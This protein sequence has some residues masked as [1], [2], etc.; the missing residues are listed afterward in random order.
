MAG[1]RP[2]PHHA[3]PSRH[4]V[5]H[6]GD[7][8]GEYGGHPMHGVHPSMPMHHMQSVTSQY[9]TSSMVSGATSMYMMERN[10]GTTG[11]PR[12]VAAAAAGPAAIGVAR[13]LDAAA[14]LYWR[15]AA[16]EANLLS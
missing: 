13:C 6:P 4:V 12:Y 8:P 14:C 11:S 1:G 5:G 10:D 3:P 9:N 15:L 2:E 7:Y 16:G